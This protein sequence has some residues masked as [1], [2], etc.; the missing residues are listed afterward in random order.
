MYFFLPNDLIELWV[1]C[2]LTCYQIFF[3]L[4]IEREKWHTAQGLC[5]LHCVLLL[6]EELLDFF[7]AA[8]VF[9]VAL[10]QVTAGDPSFQ[11]N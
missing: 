4:G 8:Y 2:F 11:S 1:R 3:K 10:L 5:H 7:P 9:M 6:S